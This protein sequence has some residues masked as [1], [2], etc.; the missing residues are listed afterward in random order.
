VGSGG[1]KLYQVF[2][3]SCIPMLIMSCLYINIL[4]TSMAIIENDI[5]RH[6]FSVVLN[7]VFSALDNQEISAQS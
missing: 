4:I 5:V 2:E 7:G 3:K 1:Y 6:L